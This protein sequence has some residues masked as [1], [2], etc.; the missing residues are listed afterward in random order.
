M[1]YVSG[2]WSTDDPVP[3][4]S[5]FRSD[6]PSTASTA[7]QER[8][9]GPGAVV[10]PTTSCASR[11]GKLD[12]TGHVWSPAATVQVTGPGDVP[13]TGTVARI[14]HVPAGAAGTVRSVVA[15]V[16]SSESVRC[17]A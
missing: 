16:I 2:V 14:H 4:R 5:A 3:T 7:V 1:P 6:A 12:E 10:V 17:A 11:L 15:D 9:I 8:V 13:I